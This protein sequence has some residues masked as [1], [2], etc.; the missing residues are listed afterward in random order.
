MCLNSRVNYKLGYGY[1]HLILLHGL[2]IR[3]LVGSTIIAVSL[4][5]C[6]SID[7]QNSSTSTSNTSPI[8][9]SNISTWKSN[10]IVEYFNELVFGSEFGASNKRCKK[11]VKNIKIFVAGKYPTY[12]DAELNK[13]I[14]EINNLTGVVKLLRVTSKQDANYVIYFGSGKDY[15]KIE[16]NA[17]PY[18][19]DNYGLFWVYWNSNNE[20]YKGSM[21]VALMGARDENTQ[22]HLL[23][24]ELTQSLGIMNDSDKYSK[25]IFYQGWTH[26][27]EYL[28]IDKHIIKL[29]Y[30]QALEANMT[31]QE[32]NKIIQSKSLLDSL[33]EIHPK[34]IK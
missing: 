20:I 15:S 19:K 25:S 16:P 6:I 22:K 29:L 14:K 7:V 30:N 28:E 18:V 23:R 27:T 26:T 11:W 31:K 8:T 3:L 13:I 4:C 12:L 24:E 1:L 9:V 33:R 5:A 34:G 2:M 21:Y 32:I 17:R 10:D